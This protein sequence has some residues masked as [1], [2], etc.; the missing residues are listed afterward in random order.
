MKTI[1]IKFVDMFKGFDEQDNDFYKILSKH[2][3]VVFSN[4]PDYIFYSCFG[5]EHLKYNCIRI[6]YT[7]ECFSPD[8]NE[9]DYAIGFDRIK[10][11]DRYCRVPLY[12]LFQYKREYDVI[13]KESRFSLSDLQKKSRFCGFVYSNQFADDARSKIF[14]LLSSYKEVSSGGKFLNNV[15]GPV[16]DKI[17]FLKNCKFSIAFENTVYPGYTT[18]KIV[19]SFVSNTIPIYYGNNDVALDFNEK[20]FINCNNYSSLEDVVER[21]KEIDNND[22]LYLKIINADKV[23]NCSEISLEE[24]ICSIMDR[25]LI[26]AKRRPDSFHT[27]KYINA[28]KR[29]AFFEDNVYKF[30]AKVKRGIY[31]STH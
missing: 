14:N 17:E 11:G 9:C 4:T 23:I 24:F 26:R 2:Y 13:K 27:L 16:P 25:D 1:K 22:E 31:R 6:F 29:H 5:Y 20:S 15:G 8:F 30:Y 19:D 7:G 28:A 3:N 21:V 18:E 10:F 12:M